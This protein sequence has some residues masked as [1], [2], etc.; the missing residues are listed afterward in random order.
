MQTAF[1]SCSPEDTAMLA[2]PKDAVEKL[3][4][5]LYALGIRNYWNFSHYDIASEFPGVAVENVHLS[6]SLMKL[7]YKLNRKK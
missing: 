7:S 3:I 5:K 4:D 2:L 1:T 6:E